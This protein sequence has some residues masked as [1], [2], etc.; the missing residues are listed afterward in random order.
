MALLTQTSI[1]PKVASTLSAAAST[2]AASATSSGRTSAFLPRDSISFATCPSRSPLREIRA[3]SV[4]AAAYASA[5]ARPMP[6][7]APVTT[8]MLKRRYPWRLGYARPMRAKLLNENG[9][10]MFAVVFETGDDPVAGLTRFAAER[11]LGASAFTAIG[12]FS[13]A[14]LGYFDWDEKDYERIAV[15][16]QVE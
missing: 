8:A 3:T 1:G 10:R 15:K 4:P 6:A 2:A 13:E 16:E 5:V 7:E 9:E 12:A 14:T 11:K